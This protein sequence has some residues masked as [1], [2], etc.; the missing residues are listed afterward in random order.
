MDDRDWVLIDVE[1]AGLS[2]PVVVELAAQRMRGWVPQGPAWR[3][4]L[5]HGPDMNQDRSRVHGLSRALIERDGE[6]PAQ[7]Y[8]E[9]ADYVDGLPLVAFDLPQALHRALQPEWVRLGIAPIGTEGFCAL[10][11]AQRLLDPV[12]VVSGKLQTLRQYYRLPERTPA[13]ALGE[14]ETGV[15]L[16]GTVLQ[17]LAMRRGLHSWQAVCEHAQAPWYPSRLAFG[18]FKGRHFREALSDPALHAWLA[19]LA[20]SSSPRSASMGRWYLA[21]L[22]EPAPEA[23]E[24]LAQVETPAVRGAQG[25]PVA[26]EPAQAGVLVFVKPEVDELK[27]LIASARVRLADLEARYTQERHDIDVTQARLFGLLRPHYQQRDRLRLLVSY[28]RQYLDALVYDG[29]EA[30]EAVA[31]QCEEAWQQSDAEYEQVAFEAAEQKALPEDE[32]RELKSLW[33]K[34]VRLFHPDRFAH[35]AGKLAIFQQ[36][37]SEINR[38]RDSGDVQRLREIAQDPNAFLLKQGWG[39]LDFSDSIE[40]ASLRKLFETL[41]LQ[42]VLVLDALNELRRDARYELHK[43]SQERVGY[44][45]EVARTH[46]QALDEEIT[47]LAAESGALSDEIEMLTGRPAPGALL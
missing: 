14:V 38:A 35:D 31:Q 34:L 10:R 44:L 6:A 42:I 22:A 23:D 8:R 29:E 16:L 7:V 2:S 13:S 32:A 5:N 47:A 11:L 18:E 39:H 26:A 33:R 17:P 43:L 21:Q 9:W 28:R 24:A 40:A 19:W 30:A 45:E 15:D 27:A 4:L 1:T 3:R 37:T 25:E 46:A 36:L 20:G 12:P 41:Q